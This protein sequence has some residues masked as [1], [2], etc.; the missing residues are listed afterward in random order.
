[1][2]IS[3]ELQISLSDNRVEV[4]F[5]LQGRK[6]MAGSFLTWS[7][8]RLCAYDEFSEEWSEICRGLV[9]VECQ[10]Q[11]DR[12]EIEKIA[13]ENACLYEDCGEQYGNPVN[14]ESI[15]KHFSTFGANFGP[16]FRSLQNIRWNESEEA[17]ATMDLNHR[18]QIIPQKQTRPLFASIMQHSTDFFISRLYLQAKERQR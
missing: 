14:P 16:S 5:Y 18:A 13:L 4:E 12:K 9:A 2:K 10:D 3:K 1:M 6:E 15:Y 8:F 17:I 7:S 11:M